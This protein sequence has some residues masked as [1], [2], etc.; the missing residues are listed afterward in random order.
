MCERQGKQ[1]V[2]GKTNS[3]SNRET[4]RQIRGRQRRQTEVRDR[5]LRKP[6]EVR[7]ADRWEGRK[8]KETNRRRTHDVRQ[9]DETETDE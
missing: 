3:L 6:M 5:Q 9:M 2:G 8:T 4:G 1:R 7:Q